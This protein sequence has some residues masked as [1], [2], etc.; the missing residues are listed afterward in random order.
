M[1]EIS[2]AR[3]SQ[4]ELV[5]QIASCITEHKQASTIARLQRKAW[6]VSA[7]THW[8]STQEPGVLH[9]SAFIVILGGL[10]IRDFT[11]TY[12]NTSV[13]IISMK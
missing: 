4:L 11:A 12:H 2:I 7:H 13:K 3:L 5:N 6:P 8:R 1:G 10:V 9:F